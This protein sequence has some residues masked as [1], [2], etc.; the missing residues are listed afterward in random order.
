MQC[1]IYRSDVR[2]GLYVWL[3]TDDGLDTLPQAVR[4]QLGT[5]ELAMSIDL[6]PGQ[7]L[8]QEDPA[9]VI[10]NLKS[11]GFHVQ[12]PRDIEPDVVRAVLDSHKPR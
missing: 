3:A 11:Q 4:K 12:M 7:K 1:W 9:V 6:Q 2:E 8:G 5:A 10:A